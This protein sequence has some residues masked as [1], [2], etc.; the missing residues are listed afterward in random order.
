M[1]ADLLFFAVVSMLLIHEMDAVR[2][3]EWRIFPFLSRLDDTRAYRVFL[4]AHVPL[5]VVLLWFLC[6]AAG[7]GRIIFQAL[8]DS[9]A[10]IHLG[11][12]LILWKNRR[13]EFTA[14]F[15]SI[16]IVLTALAG[17]IHLFLLSP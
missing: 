16:I 15:S 12:H 2:R 6:R 4:I 10:I 5:F 3:H 1:I 14:P 9:F 8:V 11:L 13:N 17:S 7:E